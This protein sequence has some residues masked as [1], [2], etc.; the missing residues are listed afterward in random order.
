MEWQRTDLGAKPVLSWCA[1]VDGGALK[2]AANLA[3]H[4]AVFRHVALMPDCHVGY[5]MPI[6]GVIA[7]ERAVIPN[8]VGV[9]IGCGM[10][11]VGTNLAASDLSTERIRRVL[12]VVKELTPL[13]EGH[14]HRLPQTWDGLRERDGNLPGGVDDHG[15][16]LAYRNLGSLGGGNHFIELQAAGDNLVWL[17]IHSGSRN[18]G[19]RIAEHYHR[20]ALRV[21]GRGKIE[22]PDPELAFLPL[23]TDEA[24]DYIRD[25]TF[26]LAY[27]RENRA[28]IMKSFQTAVME[29]CPGVEFDPPINIHHN[30]AAEEEHFGRRVWLHRKGATSARKGEIGI[31]PGSMGTHSYIVR[32]LGNP[33]AFQS[34]SHGAGRRMG[35]ME[36]CRT[37]DRD[38]CDRAMAG[39][40]FDGWKPLQK[41]G[42]RRGRL[43]DLE[44]A[45]LAY[46]D[47]DA[48]IAAQADLV[49]PIIRLRPIGVAKG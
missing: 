42:G 38:A 46:K 45:P 13:G 11:A 16:D 27:A 34:C 19:L 20:L 10:G 32:G 29:T 8:A 31:I 5:G 9:D 7:C 21:N 24:Q 12:S 41:R 23:D 17:M 33:E 35:R 3:N 18:L 49:E 48:V 2:Q 28:R 37:L 39:V 4:P 26:A 6:G 30:Y 44:E 1:Q 40:V 43:L 25:M 36:A 14:A 15:W 47:I 22:L